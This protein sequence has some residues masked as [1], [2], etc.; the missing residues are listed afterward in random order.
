MNEPHTP[1]GGATPGLGRPGAARDDLDRYDRPDADLGS[2]FILAAAVVVIGLVVAAAEGLVG[3]IPTAT[4][5]DVAVLES[6]AS[7][8]EPFSAGYALEAPLPETEK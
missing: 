7:P 4:V 8:A 2:G 5:H 3:S 1:G 6:I